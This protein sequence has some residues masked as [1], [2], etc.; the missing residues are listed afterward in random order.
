MERN[1][2]GKRTKMIAELARCMC[3]ATTRDVVGQR[4]PFA[5]DEKMSLR[6]QKGDV[7]T[8]ECRASQSVYHADISTYATTDALA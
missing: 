4:L 1:R 7:L 6:R 2:I 8:F 3:K 5:A